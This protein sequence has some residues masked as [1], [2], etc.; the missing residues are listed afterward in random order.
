LHVFN[1]YCRLTKNHKILCDKIHK[2]NISKNINMQYEHHYKS[3]F[4]IWKVPKFICFVFNC[5]LSF[6]KILHK[7]RG[8]NVGLYRYNYWLKLWANPFLCENWHAD[9]TVVWNFFKCLFF[10]KIAQNFVRQNTKAG[11]IN[12][13]KHAAL[14]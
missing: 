10:D 4:Y 6:N 8:T 9:V 3:A 14:T 12:E 13:K 7:F 1:A 2:L 11:H 5:L